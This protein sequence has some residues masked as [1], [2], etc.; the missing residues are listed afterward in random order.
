MDMTIPGSSIEDFH[1]AASIKFV[2][3]QT[4]AKSSN[5]DWR[6]F[7]LLMVFGLP[8]A[9]TL[10]NQYRGGVQK[11]NLCDILSE[12][13]LRMTRSQDRMYALMHLAND[14]VEG[15][16]VVD[17]T[18]SG[19][20]VM[21]EAAAYHVRVHRNLRFLQHTYLQAS[22]DRHGHREQEL[23]NPTWLPRSWLGENTRI[24]VGDWPT[25]TVT[26]CLAE[27]IS[28]TD[29]R[30]HIRAM[31]VDHVGS[32]LNRGLTSGTL[33][34]CQF[35]NS[36][37]GLYLR[38]FAGPGAK[39]LPPAALEVLIRISDMQL[40]EYA[41]FARIYSEAKDDHAFQSGQSEWDENDKDQNLTIVR[42]ASSSALSVLLQLAQDPLRA[43]Q[44]IF[45]DCALN[46]ELLE[47]VDPVTMAML[48]ELLFSLYDSLIIKTQTEG[49]GRVVNSAIDDAD[50]IWIALG[51]DQPIVLRPQPS[52]RYWFV[53]A[54]A[55]PDIQK[56]EILKQFTSDVQPEDKIGEWIVEDIEIE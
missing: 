18:K 46:T 31:R 5:K 4:S 21:V 44:Y 51:C 30:L 52:G 36:S 38:D 7:L 26:S 28:T 34:T 22:S 54:A 19:V 53:C 12:K 45:Q 33:T 29:R 37:L 32:C 24:N 47:T 14:Y 50:E 15:G 56:D 3:L 23:Y 48:H 8:P 17:Y 27:S 16:I 43:D 35:W 1:L 39:C 20:D 42:K 55:I 13:G 40:K 6:R 41:K 10:A 9:I 11:P 49:L 25:T 2:N